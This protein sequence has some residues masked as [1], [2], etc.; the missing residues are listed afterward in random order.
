MIVGA[1]PAGLFAAQELA[2]LF[3][4]TILEKNN[5]SGGSGLNSDGKLNFN[6]KIGGDLT[7]FLQLEEAENVI[8]GIDKTF[9]NYGVDQND[10]Y[11]DGELEK[12]RIKADQAGMEFVK[13]KQKHIGSDR[14]HEVMERFQEDLERKSVKFRFLTDVRHLKHDGKK[15]TEVETSKGSFNSDFV[16]LAPG[17]T[18]SLQLKPVIDKLGLEYV[19]NPVDIGVRVE[20]PSSLMKE[21]VED[22]KCW[23]PKFRMRT[24]TYDDRVR[25]FC[26][27]PYGYVFLESYGDSLF[28]VNGYSEFKNILTIQTLLF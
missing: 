26:T 4:V 25:T 27:C 18:G 22:N 7:E 21:I 5:V 23:D 1:G 8:D 12:L 20:F 28:G 15:V 6:P 13:I 11:N 24:P 9:Q 19:F 10:N 16:I 3:D 2:E 14:L 17:R